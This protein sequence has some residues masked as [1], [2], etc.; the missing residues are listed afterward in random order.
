MSAEK[1]ISTWV[2]HQKNRWGNYIVYYSDQALR[3]EGSS[4]GV[5]V[6]KAPKWDVFLYHT[7]DKRCAQI[8]LKL[9]TQKMSGRVNLKA[10]KQAPV[11]EKIAQIDVLTYRFP[12]NS[13]VDVTG[14]TNALYQS[15]MINKYAICSVFSFDA[16]S[17]RF[18][19]IPIIIWNCFLEFPYSGRV[20]INAYILVKNGEKELVLESTKQESKLMPAS[21]FEKPQG[22]KMV[23]DPPLSVFMGKGILDATEL[24]F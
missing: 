8:P 19:T 15:R 22:L 17:K 3:I 14:G 23:N 9:W 21:K 24:L 5:L 7:R 18:N 6:S 4:Q 13:E 1:Q 16:N 20:P 11:K 2:V 12:I 10:M